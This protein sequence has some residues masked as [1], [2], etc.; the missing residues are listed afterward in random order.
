MGY[1]K[2]NTSGTSVLTWGFQRYTLLLVVMHSHDITS[3]SLKTENLQKDADI[4]DFGDSLWKFT[5]G[6]C[7]EM[8]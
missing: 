8:C 2:I 7:L 1:L 3:K 4:D 6:F 5:I